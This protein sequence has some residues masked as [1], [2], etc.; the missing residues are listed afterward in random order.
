MHCLTLG[1]K[2]IS[3][4]IS[5]FLLWG[6]IRMPHGEFVENEAARSADWVT[7]NVQMGVFLAARCRRA[8]LAR[9]SLRMKRL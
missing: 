1:H 5:Q 2:K 9:W 3:H 6:L 7:P 4:S 8:C